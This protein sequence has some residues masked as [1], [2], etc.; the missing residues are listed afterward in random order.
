[1]PAHSSNFKNNFAPPLDLNQRI[2]LDHAAH[3]LSTTAN[4]LLTL[5][6]RGDVN[7]TLYPFG[8]RGLRVIYKDVIALNAPTD[9]IE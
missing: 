5:I 3:L 8:R 9:V 7:L 1:M 6:R 2:T 4:S